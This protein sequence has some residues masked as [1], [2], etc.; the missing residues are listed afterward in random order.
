MVAPLSQRDHSIQSAEKQLFIG[1]DPVL[2]IEE[3]CGKHFPIPRLQQSLQGLMGKMLVGE[4][5]AL[6]E[7]LV[8]HSLSMVSKSSSVTNSVTW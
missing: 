6:G 8:G 7:F 2:V 4:G 1:Q 3:Q 5:H